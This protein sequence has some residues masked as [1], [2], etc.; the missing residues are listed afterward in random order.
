MFLL[1]QWSVKSSTMPKQHEE[2][3]T[4]TTCI[5]TASIS[6][7]RVLHWHDLTVKHDLHVKHS[8]QRLC[9]IAETVH[10]TYRLTQLIKHN[11]FW[12]IVAQQWARPPTSCHLIEHLKTLMMKSSTQ[13]WSKAQ[14][15]WPYRQ[16]SLFS[17]SSAKPQSPNE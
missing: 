9:M 17:K 16:K 7:G 5:K 8:Y 4:G 11:R 14:H 2:K 6:C 15:C 12:L 13:L 1:P 10:I 3:R